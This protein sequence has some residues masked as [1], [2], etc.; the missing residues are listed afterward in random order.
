MML[1]FIFSSEAIA[2]GIFCLLG[3]G[4]LLP[5]FVLTNAVLYYQNRFCGKPYQDSF[6]SYY[7][8]A[9]NIMQPVGLIFTLYYQDKI[10]IQFLILIPLLVYTCLFV[11]N[12][13]IVLIPVVNATALFALTIITALFCGGCSAIMNGG[14]FGLAGMLPSQYTAA[15]MNGQGFAGLLVSSLSFIVTASTSRK[16]ICN[17]DDDS[18]SKS[19]DSTNECDKTVDYGDFIYFLVATIILLACVTFFQVLMRLDF[20]QQQIHSR[21]KEEEN[22]STT[23]NG[24]NID[25]PIISGQ[26]DVHILKGDTIPQIQMSSMNFTT[27]EILKK[28]YVPACSV[29]FLFFLSISLMPSV[30]A[31]MRSTQNCNPGSSRWNND[32]FIPMLFLLYNIGDFSGRLTA[33]ITRNYD[34]FTASNIWFPTILRIIPYTLC[35]FCN[36]DNS[37]LPFTLNSNAAPIVLSVLIGLTNGFL[38][39][40]AMMKAPPLVSAEYASKAGTIM[41]CCLIMGLCMGSALGVLNVYIITGSA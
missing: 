20:V 33:Q 34:V 32:L 23:T 4:N 27:I 1:S 28:L 6:E 25:N 21:L 16:D 10:S 36:A 9:Y 17:D 13:A 5:W 8:V 29:F 31:I 26:G 18:I 3:V 40:I 11:I 19:D 39:N 2:Y 38:G 24:Q 30:F 41:V 12:T 7:S 15:L 22:Y 14:L 37:R 35:L